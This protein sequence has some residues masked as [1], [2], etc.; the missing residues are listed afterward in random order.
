MKPRVLIFSSAPLSAIGGAEI[1]TRE[2]VRRLAGDFEFDVISADVTNPRS[3][4]F[5]PWWASWEAFRRHQIKNYDLVWA[6]MA[7]QAG[8]AAAR[9]KQKFPTVPFLLTLQEGDELDSWFYRLRLLGPRWFRVFNRADKIH[10]ISNYLADWAKR[11]GARCPVI[12]VPNGIDV[13]K[14]KSLAK[15][16]W[17]PHVEPRLITTSRLVRK[18]GVDVLIKALA[19][20]PKSVC[21]EI[22]GDGPERQALES[23]AANLGLTARVFFLG[24]L[25]PELVPARLAAAHVF[26]RPA[27]SEGL[28]NSFL[29]AMAAGLPVIGTPMGGIPDFLRDGETGWLVPPNNPFALAEKIKFVLDSGNQET[30]KR[31]TQVGF[32]LAQHRYRWSL[33][34]NEI[35]AMFRSLCASS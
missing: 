33:I 23:L 31:V 13:E 9:F 35:S 18:N 10:A 26:V 22:A 21:L 20:L 1:A 16:P 17:S 12:V 32:D 27:R 24:V 25:S 29:E 30:V 6:I 11:M 14:F 5:Y 15:E 7:N 34:A 28:G 4:Y 19:F 2:L 8:M 3:K